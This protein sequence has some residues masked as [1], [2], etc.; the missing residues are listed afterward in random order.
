MTKKTFIVLH[1]FKN[2]DYPT[3]ATH[4][5]FIRPDLI[6][7][8]HPYELGGSWLQLTTGGDRLYVI[9][10]VADIMSLLES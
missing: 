9:E 1:A 6:G 8:V 2:P 10:T 4:E 7:M 3:H 5:F